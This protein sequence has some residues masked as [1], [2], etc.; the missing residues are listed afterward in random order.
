MDH[1]EGFLRGRGNPFGEDR[2]FRMAYIAII[3]MSVA[4]AVVYGVVHDQV[5]VRVCIEYFT[6]GHPPVLGIESPTL[7]GL[8]WGVV[9]TRRKTAGQ[10]HQKLTATGN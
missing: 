6:I 10:N 1:V 2:T 7:L 8:Y 3:S 9:A 4:A 5:T